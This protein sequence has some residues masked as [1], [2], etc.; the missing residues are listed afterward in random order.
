MIDIGEDF[1]VEVGSTV[2]LQVNNSTLDYV[3]DWAGSNG[4]TATGVSISTTINENTTFA[5][6][7]TIVGCP[8]VEAEINI[9]V[10]SEGE[11][12][13]PNAFSPN[14]DGKNDVF[15]VVANLPIVIIEFKVFNR[16]GE[17]IYNNTE[18]EWDGTHN[19]QM[20]QNGGYI[21]IIQYVSYL[22]E[23]VTEKGEVVLIR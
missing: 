19:G 2:T 16:Y 8:L 18:G 20:V 17:I 11:V 15:R 21:Y 4:F 22:G 1:V 7:G 13:V 6:S 14:Q 23:E 5:V 9:E 3:Y 12:E 10:V